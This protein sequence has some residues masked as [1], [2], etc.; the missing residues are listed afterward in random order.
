MPEMLS[1]NSGEKKNNE[2][3]SALPSSQISTEKLGLASISKR[4][5]KKI[6]S[7]L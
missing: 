6:L 2:E 7:I 3:S 1:N 5:K 4:K